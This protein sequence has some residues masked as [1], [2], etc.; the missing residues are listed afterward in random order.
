MSDYKKLFHL[1]R[2]YTLKII[3][4]VILNLLYVFFSIVSISLLAP[5]LSLIFN[6][7]PQVIENL[8]LHF[9]STT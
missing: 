3:L 9:L 5:F 7:I 6:Q 4:I 2:P 8:P 1:L